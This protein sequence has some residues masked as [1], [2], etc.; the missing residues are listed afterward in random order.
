VVV[1]G[2]LALVAAKELRELA[3]GPPVR[4]SRR[5]VRPLTW[6]GALGEQPAELV[7]RPRRLAQNPVRVMVDEPDRAQYL[8]K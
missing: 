8:R 5:H 3:H 6:V 7:Q 2:L 4:H 1:D